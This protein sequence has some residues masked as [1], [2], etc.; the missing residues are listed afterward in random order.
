MMSAGLEEIAR[1][2]NWYTDPRQV[3][4]DVEGF[5]CQVMA[6]GTF[7]DMLTILERFSRDELRS[8]Y[9]AAPAG[10]F[11]RRA[12]AYWGLMLLGDADRP[13]P[14]RFAGANRFDWRRAT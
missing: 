2:V 12:W 3:L 14:E 11:T 10:L 13:M 7:E 1:R 6:R 5:L 9:L 8:A 4:A